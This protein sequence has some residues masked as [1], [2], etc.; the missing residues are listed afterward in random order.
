MQKLGYEK[1]TWP[2]LTISLEFLASEHV[3]VG[4]PHFAR[5]THFVHCFHH[6]PHIAKLLDEVIYLL[7]RSAA[8]ICDTFPSTPIQDFRII[9]FFDGHG[10][11]NGF[12]WFKG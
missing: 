8:T 12:D 7:D 9:S 11:D 2:L 5:P 6:L 10:A 4:K 1:G 3:H